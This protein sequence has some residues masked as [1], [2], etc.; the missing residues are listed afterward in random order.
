MYYKDVMFQLKKH[1]KFTCTVT[2]QVLTYGMNIAIRG[3]VFV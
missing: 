1:T 3:K 2:T